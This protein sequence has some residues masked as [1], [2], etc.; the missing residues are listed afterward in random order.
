M[1]KKSFYLLKKWLSFAKFKRMWRRNNFHN[2]TKVIN[3]SFQ[4]SK[5]SVGKRTYGELD[6]ISWG[7]PGEELKIGNYVS[8]APGVKFLLGG[9][10]FYQG[11]TTYPFKVKTGLVNNEAIS[12]G[13]IFVGDDVWIGME[14]LIMS[15]VTIGQGAIVAARSVVTKDVPAY[16]IVA[17]NPAQVIKYRFSQSVIEKLQGFDWVSIS[18]KDIKENLALLYTPIDENNIDEILSSLNHNI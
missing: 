16:A 12:K 4:I 15:G 14:A 7:Q 2:E 9:N 17:G 10:H 3:Q 11:L 18:E 5:V 13:P 6:I 1:V 8:I